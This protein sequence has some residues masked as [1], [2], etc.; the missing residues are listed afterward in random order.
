MSHKISQTLIEVTPHLTTTLHLLKRLKLIHI[1]WTVTLKFMERQTFTALH[2]DAF[3]YEDEYY[4][5][6]NF[7]TVQ[8]GKYSFSFM[9]ILKIFIFSIF[10]NFSGFSGN[11]MPFKVYFISSKKEKKK[12]PGLRAQDCAGAWL[13]GKMTVCHKQHRLSN[14]NTD[15]LVFLFTCLSF[16][17]LLH[18][19]F[20]AILFLNMFLAATCLLTGTDVVLGL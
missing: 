4:T 12:N 18:H 3:I 19:C 2:W 17:C 9:S 20:H 5:M 1:N 16:I 13:L 10:I 8:F 15:F 7:L 6:C 11:L 14:G